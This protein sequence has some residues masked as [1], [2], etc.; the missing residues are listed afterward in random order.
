MTLPLGSQ[1]CLRCGLGQGDPLLL[2]RQ[3]V[4]ES[5]GVGWVITGGTTPGVLEDDVRVHGFLQLP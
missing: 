1:E 2:P 4:L 5:P 3:Q